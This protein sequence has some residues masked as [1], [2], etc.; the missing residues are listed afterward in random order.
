LMK[1]V[2]AHANALLRWCQTE[3]S[4]SGLASAGSFVEFWEQ[5]WNTMPQ[6][7]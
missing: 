7:T 4:Q 2:L 5:P 3:S 6:D 1:G